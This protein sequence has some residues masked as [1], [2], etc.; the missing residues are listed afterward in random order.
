MITKG[1]M[2]PEG[3]IDKFY[4]NYKPPLKSENIKQIIQ[5]DKFYPC[6][7]IEEEASLFFQILIN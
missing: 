6:F 5:I 7:K 1:K 3:S 4:N 2:P